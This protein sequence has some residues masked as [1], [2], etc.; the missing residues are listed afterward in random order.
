MQKI[1]VLKGLPGSGKTTYAF[2]LMKKE[3][4]V[5]KRINKD[6]LRSMVDGG[7]FSRKNEKA[8]LQIRDHLIRIFLTQGFNVIVDDTNL[9]PVHERTI[10]D[11]V[12]K[13]MEKNMIRPT[14]IEVKEFVVPLDECIARDAKRNG[15]EQVGEKVIREMWEK[16]YSR[17]EIPSKLRLAYPIQP[18]LPTIVICDI[19]GTLALHENRRSPF[20]YD[21]VG[22]DA[23]NAPIALILNKL[24]HQFPVFLV[25][26]RDEL[27]RKQTMDWLALHG[28]PYSNLLMRKHKDNRK[29]TIVKLEMFD[30]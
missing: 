3:P 25:S 16:Y 9:A 21:K 22:L 26:G 7:Q 8:I 29:D 24:A 14:E 17:N 30:R 18:H 6:S 13:G 19:D 15:R 5:W 1:L 4:E 27:C 12:E 23:I 20:E 2:E 10:R 28:I 11:L